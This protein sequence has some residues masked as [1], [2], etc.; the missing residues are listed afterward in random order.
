MIRRFACELVIK[1]RMAGVQRKMSF[2]L[3]TIFL[4]SVLISRSPQRF[5]LRNGA[6][7][8]STDFGRREV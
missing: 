6:V 5:M 1:T 2:L 4:K 3:C 7:S 8:F